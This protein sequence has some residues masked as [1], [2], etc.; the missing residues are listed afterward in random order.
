MTIGILGFINNFIGILDGP[1]PFIDIF[2]M[3]LQSI[4]W[5]FI[6]LNAPINLIIRI[7]L[8]PTFLLAGFLWDA[9]GGLPH[10]AFLNFIPLTLLVAYSMNIRHLNYIII[11]LPAILT[12]WLFLGISTPLCASV[13]EVLILLDT[14]C[15][16]FLANIPFIGW[17]FKF[18]LGC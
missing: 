8:I 2:T 12:V 10:L 9:M 11:A 18:I 17:V 1:L 3:F 4:I 15:K 14:P 16:S 7:I 5:M 6:I 13:N